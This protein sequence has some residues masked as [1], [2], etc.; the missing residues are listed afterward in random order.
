[1]K[2]TSSGETGSAW[3]DEG[4]LH[5]E[6]MGRQGGGEYKCEGEG[7]TRTRQENKG[8]EVS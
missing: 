8:G 3:G 6:R 7:Q 5:L 2:G 4:R 1:M